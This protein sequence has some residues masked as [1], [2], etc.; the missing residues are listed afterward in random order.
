MV[1]N[2]A[3]RETAPSKDTQDL[4]VEIRR[5]QEL[6]ENQFRAV[7]STGV[8]DR[9]GTSFAPLGAD[10]RNW[11]ANP[12]VY[13]RHDRGMLPIG[14][15]T[16]L[17][18]TSDGRWVADF[19]VDGFTEFERIVIKKLNSGTLNAVSIGAHV[20]RSTIEYDERT[21]TEIYNNWELYEF[22]VVGIGGNP[23]ALVTDRSMPEDAT[24]EDYLA[25]FNQIIADHIAERGIVEPEKEEVVLTV[26]ERVEVLENT[27]KEMVDQ[28]AKRDA[29]YGKPVNITVEARGSLRG[30]E[31]ANPEP[32]ISEQDD[33]EAPEDRSYIDQL[34]YELRQK[35]LEEI[36]PLA[37][38]DLKD[39][40]F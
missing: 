3:D 40:E 34:L 9:Y 25:E 15:G 12:V 29:D 19:E 37:G 20:D 30:D 6:G 39:F 7:I 24:A 31:P 1:K 33:T 5:D 35:D 2:K 17:T 26:E 22:S 18:L 13:Y 32:L 38:L 21:E 28:L 11:L 36:H 8:R 27:I 14:H 16:A 23:E 10:T 4:Q